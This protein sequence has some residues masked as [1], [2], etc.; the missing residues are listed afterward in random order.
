MKEPCD[1]RNLWRLYGGV[2][3]KIAKFA[4]YYAADQNLV[5]TAGMK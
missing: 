1:L 2:C 4:N 5:W 3:G